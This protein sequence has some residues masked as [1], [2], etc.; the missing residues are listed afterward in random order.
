M[1]SGEQSCRKPR[2]AGVTL[3]PRFIWMPDAN[4]E[5]A[6]NLVTVKLVCARV[7]DDFVDG[8]DDCVLFLRV[9]YENK[10]ATG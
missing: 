4:I 1:N 7:A 5:P 10:I 6:S 9:G 2:I 8:R 3:S